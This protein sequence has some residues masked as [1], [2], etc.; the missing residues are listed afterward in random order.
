MLYKGTESVGK[1]QSHNSAFGGL[2]C[3]IRLQSGKLSISFPL[4]WPLNIGLIVWAP[5][6]CKDNN[7]LVPFAGDKVLVYLSLAVEVPRRISVAFKENMY[8]L[9]WDSES[10]CSA[11]NNF[12]GSKNLMH[13]TTWD[14]MQ[15]DHSDSALV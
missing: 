11:W 12:M 13:L 14:D 3:L 4:H 1:S 10:L 15:T 2:N 9:Q 5:E 8:H 6:L 7:S